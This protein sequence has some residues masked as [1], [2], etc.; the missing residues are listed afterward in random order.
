MFLIE[1]CRLEIH[2]ILNENTFH[3]VAFV[4]GAILGW[5]RRK[6]DR[7][8][9]VRMQH[10]GYSGSPFSSALLSLWGCCG[11]GGLYVGFIPSLCSV[12]FPLLIF[13]VLYLFNKKITRFKKTIKS[14]FLEA[15]QLLFL[16]CWLKLKHGSHHWAKRHRPD[17]RRFLAPVTAKLELS[18]ANWVWGSRY[19]LI[20][21]CPGIYFQLI[22]IEYTAAISDSSIVI[23][24]KEYQ[25]L[26][27]NK[28]LWFQ[29]FSYL[30]KTNIV[31]LYISD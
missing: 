15:D 5:Y 29:E 31:V 9:I 2:W 17:D 12:L 16:L 27:L 8:N 24:T 14:E 10:T 6:I 4:F 22:Y 13:V 23:K 3:L 11:V 26:C 18:C 20:V 21:S 19:L 1:Q 7:M 30:N 28:K 25:S